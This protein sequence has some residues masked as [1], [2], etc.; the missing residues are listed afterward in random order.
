MD[1]EIRLS[2]FGRAN[3]R[4]DWKR[5]HPAVKFSMAWQEVNFN[6][7]WSNP[8]AF[9]SLL[10]GIEQSGEPGACLSKLFS[11]DRR[12]NFL[13]ILTEILV[14]FGHL[15]EAGQLAVGYAGLQRSRRFDGERMRQ[16]SVNDLFGQLVA[17]PCP[18]SKIGSL[19]LPRGNRC[20]ELLLQ[21]I[22]DIPCR[23]PGGEAL[24]DFNVP[25]FVKIGDKGSTSGHGRGRRVS[26]K[27][28]RNAVAAEVVVGAGMEGLMNVTEEMNGKSQSIGAR[29][30]G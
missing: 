28:D 2:V 13:V 9:P 27:R 10:E 25:H 15:G 6:V 18:S 12:G 5:R 3:Y 24:D 1:S 4:L 16:P 17:F 26:E 22:G 29:R 11:D 23:F 14:D 20:G 7:C 19:G 21:L 30:G 8:S